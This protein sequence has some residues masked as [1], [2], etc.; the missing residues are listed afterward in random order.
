VRSPQKANGVWCLLL[1]TSIVLSEVG[2]VSPTTARHAFPTTLHRRCVTS[3]VRVTNAVLSRQQVLRASAITDPMS[4]HRRCVTS[5]V[6]MTKAVLSRQQ[7]L[8][9][10]AI[11]TD[12]M[13]TQNHPSRAI[14]PARWE[15]D[16]SLARMAQHACLSLLIVQ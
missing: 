7:V 16:A 11:T 5:H 13:P 14:L 6:Q 1:V 9:A 2:V 15:L 12:P 8:R 10:F 3:I 4:F